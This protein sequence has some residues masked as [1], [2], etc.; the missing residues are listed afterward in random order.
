MSKSE[1]KFALV[2]T[3]V[4]ENLPSSEIQQV[5]RFSTVN[6][7]AMLLYMACSCSGTTIAMCDRVTPA[8]SQ[9]STTGSVTCSI[10]CTE[11]T[12]RNFAHDTNHFYSRT[13]HLACPRISETKHVF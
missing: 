1:M 12:W 3:K 7:S 10:E 11:K 4:L 9:V 5:Q 2:M 8:L 6:E 13:Y